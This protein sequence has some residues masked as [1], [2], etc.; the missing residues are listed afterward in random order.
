MGNKHTLKGYK[1]LPVIT[2]A[3]AP[4]ILATS[5]LTRPIGPGY[6]VEKENIYN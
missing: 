1:D 3:A 2:T 6:E 4:I 5:T